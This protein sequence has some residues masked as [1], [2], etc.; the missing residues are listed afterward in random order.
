MVPRGR[1][2]LP[3]ATFV[4]SRPVPPDGVLALLGRVELPPTGI[5][6][7]APGPPA[8]VWWGARESNPRPARYKLAACTNVSYR[9]VVGPAGSARTSVPWASTKCYAISATAGLVLDASLEL[10]LSTWQADVPPATPIEQWGERPVS[11][12]VK[13]GSQPDLRLT[14]DHHW[15]LRRDLNPDLNG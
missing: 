1:V 12:R 5:G 7:P 2:E 13:S 4:A 15:Y 9:P 10:A 8:R 6:N 3:A 11:R 14:P